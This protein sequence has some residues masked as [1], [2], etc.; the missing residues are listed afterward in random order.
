[1]EMSSVIELI[2][3]VGFPIFMAL[4]LLYMMRENHKRTVEIITKMNEHIR[5]NSQALTLLTNSIRCRGKDE[6]K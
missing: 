2:N 4:A 3:G 6:D 1:M 5:D